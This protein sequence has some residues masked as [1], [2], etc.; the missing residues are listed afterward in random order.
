M[1]NMNRSINFDEVEFQELFELYWNAAE[2]SVARSFVIEE[3]NKYTYF[4]A[5]GKYHTEF[6]T[7]SDFFVENIANTKKWLEEYEPS[8][9][10]SFLVYFTSKI[11]RRMLNYWVKTQKNKKYENVNEYYRLNQD[12]FVES[13]FEEKQIYMPNS[14]YDTRYLMNLGLGVLSLD[15]EIAVKLY[16]GFPLTHKDFRF[17]I[18][19]C[20]KKSTFENYRKYYTFLKEKLKSERVEREN[21]LRKLYMTS[22]LIREDA[23]GRG[24]HKRQR[25]LAYF[26][27]VRNPVPLRFIAE[28]F[29]KNIT[30]VQRKIKRGQ[31]KIKNLL[32]NQ[33]YFHFKK[34]VKSEIEKGEMRHKKAA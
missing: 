10:V 17:L 6:D 24:L 8:Y 29:Q 13:V 27:D 11:K 28:I 31:K 20:G 15:E 2:G 16:Y 14:R 7:A 26:E 5:T 32:N 12:T 21:L 9:H 1:T 33:L 23:S 30:N 4:Y 3:L 22:I 34:P 25:L 19:L 18:R